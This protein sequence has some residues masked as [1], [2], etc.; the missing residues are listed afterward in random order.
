MDDVKAAELLLAE[1]LALQK[2]VEEFDAK[3]L[4]IK[5]W[6]VTLGAAAVVAA[7]VET[8]PVVLVVAA[9]SALAFWFIEALWKQHQQAFYPRMRAIEAAFAGDRRI[10]PLQI[11]SSWSEA[12]HASRRERMLL[13]ILTWPHVWL[14][15]LP[16][17]VAGFGLFVFAPPVAA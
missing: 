2:T 10:P 15:H 8:K 17:A 11:C 4:T 9:A 14:P 5:A 1:Y 6:S 13:S 16:V 12:W 7:Y 3:A